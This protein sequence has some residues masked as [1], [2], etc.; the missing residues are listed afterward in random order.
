MIIIAIAITL[1]MSGFQTSTAQ[2]ATLLFF[3]DEASVPYTVNDKRTLQSGLSACFVL[4]PSLG[5]GEETQVCEALETAP[6]RRH[7]GMGRHAQ[8]RKPKIWIFSLG[9]LEHTIRHG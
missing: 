2:R 9:K 8:R 3:R 4:G 6:A 5:A 1:L 7:D